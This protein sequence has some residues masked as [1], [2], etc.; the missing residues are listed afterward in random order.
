MSVIIPKRAV[1]CWCALQPSSQQHGAEQ[2]CKEQHRTAVQ[3]RG[4]RVLAGVM[5]AKAAFPSVSQQRACTSLAVVVELFRFS[6]PESERSGAVIQKQRSSLQTPAVE[7]HRVLSLSLW[8]LEVGT[9]GGTAGLWG[10][11]EYLPPCSFG[12]AAC[13]AAVTSFQVSKVLQLKEVSWVFRHRW[14]WMQTGFP[15]SCCAVGL[16]H[17]TAITIIT[18]IPAWF[19][20]CGSTPSSQKAEGWDCWRCPCFCVR[21]HEGLVWSR[22]PGDS[23]ICSLVWEATFSSCFYCHKSVN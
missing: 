6:N 19:A 14:C 18:V 10:P 1:L 2:V 7:R 17:S 11:G 15:A 12:K 22:L 5:A 16:V 8:K 13:R 21:Q 20:C 23:Q 9:S 4:L 3:G